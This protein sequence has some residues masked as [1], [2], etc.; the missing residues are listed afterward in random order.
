[1]IVVAKWF[2]KW[3]R[4]YIETPDPN[5]EQTIGRLVDH[6]GYW[7]FKHADMRKIRFDFLNLPFQAIE[8]FLA[9]VQPKNGKI[10]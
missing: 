7:S 5:G 2:D 10:L 3:V 6:G 4:V 9:N 8:V 1:M